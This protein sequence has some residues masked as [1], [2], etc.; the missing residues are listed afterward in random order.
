MEFQ[1][2]C[3]ILVAGPTKAGKTELVK[4]I[5]SSANEMFS[6]PPTKIWWCFAEWQ[7]GYKDLNDKVDFVEGVPDFK[8]IK[9]QHQPQLL[10]LDD[11]MQDVK[12]DTLT[13]MFT[14]GTHHG[15]LSCIHIVQNVFYKGIRSS[16][17]NAQYIILLKNPPDRLQAMNLGRQIF[18]RKQ[19]Y[20]L[21]S[22][23]DACEKP[24]GYILIDLSQNT[25]Q[26]LRLRTNIFP[27][28]R[29]IVYVPKV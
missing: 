22:V 10:I 19:K 14:R 6:P 4:K 24:F 17:I 8:Q 12:G 7:P 3:N 13:E 2:P 28:E 21:E 11:L 29:Q 16:R 25:P 18:P 5:V 26:N 27:G 23:D 1:H 9:N 20:F 15:N